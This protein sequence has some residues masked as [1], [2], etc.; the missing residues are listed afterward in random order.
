MERVLRDVL[1][2]FGHHQRE[3]LSESDVQAKTGRNQTDI[4]A[5]LPVLAESFVLELDSDGPRYRYSGDVVVAFEIDTF[6]RRAASHQNHVA[7]N[8]ARFRERQ[9]Y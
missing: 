3:W 6:M 2:L 5:V 7:A 9:G 8:V 1:V 4:H